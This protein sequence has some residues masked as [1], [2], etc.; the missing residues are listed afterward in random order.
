ME[1]YDEITLVT[2][3]VKE[4]LME[5]EIRAAIA[6]DPQTFNDVVHAAA[7]AAYI[8]WKST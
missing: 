8:A 1:P 6:T 5:P 4:A 7:K 2:S 3:A